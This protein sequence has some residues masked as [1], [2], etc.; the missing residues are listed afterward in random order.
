MKYWKI[1]ILSTC[2]FVG[3]VCTYVPFYI[4][5]YYDKEWFAEPTDLLCCG[6]GAFCLIGLISGVM[7]L[8]EERI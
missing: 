8:I 5:H 7:Y 1:I 4:H 3:V 6:I 2:L